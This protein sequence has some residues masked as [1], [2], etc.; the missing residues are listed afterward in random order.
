MP[1]G[2][3]INILD[4]HPSQLFINRAKYDEVTRRFTVGEL[5]VEH[6]FPVIRM[7]NQVVFTDGHTRALVLW[8]HG[9]TTIN[10]YWDE[11]ELDI[12]TYRTCLKWCERAGIRRIYDLQGRMLD[13]SDYA[14]QW[15]QKCQ[16]VKKD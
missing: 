11:G 4:V 9:I 1:T 7:N 15:I 12:D 2:F 8:E 3:Q 10:V 6:P 5:D 13:P 16:Q 14:T